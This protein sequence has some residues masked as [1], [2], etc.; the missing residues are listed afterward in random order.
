MLLAARAHRALNHH[1]LLAVR[2]PPLQYL[3]HV[4]AAS[5]LVYEL[6]PKGPDS[7][8]ILYAHHGLRVLES[9]CIILVAGDVQLAGRSTSP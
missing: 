6:R 9:L 8:S 5:H 2:L 7:E 3:V 4:A 1:Q